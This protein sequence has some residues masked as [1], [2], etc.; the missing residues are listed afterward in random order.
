M[1]LFGIGPTVNT[2][3]FILILAMRRILVPKPRSS[4]KRPL[5]IP[6]PVD[7]LYFDLLPPPWRKYTTRCFCLFNMVFVHTNS[8]HVCGAGF[9][10]C[11]K[12]SGLKPLFD[13]N[14]LLQSLQLSTSV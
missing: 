14:R 11:V 6:S 13:I 7:Q 1:I 4:D 8:V 9:L 2:I 12:E 3:S 5:T 10:R